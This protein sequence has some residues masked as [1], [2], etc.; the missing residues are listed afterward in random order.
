VLALVAVMLAW[1]MQLVPASGLA[2]AVNAQ[3]AAPK[4]VFI[5]GPTGSLTD[6]NLYD[7]ERMAKQAEAVGMDVRRVFF[8]RATWQNVLD[9]I[10]GASFVVYMGHGYGWPSPYTK[11]LTETRQNGMGLNSWSGSGRNEYTYYGATR[12]RESIRLAPNAVVLLNHL[13]YA[14]GNAEPGM[15]IPGDDLARQRVDNFASGWLAVGARAVF[16]FGWWQRLNYPSAL[17]T[18]DKTMDELFMTPADGSPK[19]WTG[20]RPRRFDSQRTPGATNHLDPHSKYGFYRAVSGNLDMTAA[21]FRAGASGTPIVNDSVAPPEITALSAGDSGAAAASSSPAFHPNG[22]GLADTLTVTHTVTRPASLDITISNQ[23]G[24]LVRTLTASSPGGTST[25]RWDG[26]NNA[27]GYV[28][29]GVYTLTYTPRDSGGRTGSPMSTQA[30]VLTAIKLAKPSTVAFFARDGD[31][32]NKV[33]KFG[34][35]LNQPAR[36]NWRI[37]DAQGNVV[38]TV[39]SEAAMDAGS[40]TFAWDGRANDRSWAPDGWYRSVVTAVTDLGSYTHERT[41]YAG[42]FRIN[43]ST[44]SPARGAKLTLTILSTEALAAAPRVRVSQ[45]GLSSFTV[46]TTKVDTRKYKVT[47]TLSS[48]ADPGTLGLAVFG[49]DKNGV[50]QETAITLTLR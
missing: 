21:E 20:W 45:P 41:A 44:T 16:A 18:T 28:A 35:T 15:A 30:M 2:G 49:K 36:V 3:G 50:L 29:D 33:V 32:L 38:R 43:P 4:A 37:V 12:I 48:S 27:G 1:A 34:L 8:P 39:R 19:G 31:G 10:Q 26:R 46:G 47:F 17:M 25:S 24:N 9:N 40:V 13:C 14:S 23:A 22:D 5:V 6:Q 7:A 42:A 11:Q